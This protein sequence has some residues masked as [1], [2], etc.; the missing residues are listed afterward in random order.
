MVFVSRARGEPLTDE[1][2]EVRRAVEHRGEPS[3]FIVAEWLMMP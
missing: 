2:D 3:A 1:S